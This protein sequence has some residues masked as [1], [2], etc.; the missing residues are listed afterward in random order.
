MPAKFFPTPADF[1]NWFEAN[2][3]NETELLV[4]FYKKDTGKASITWPESVD[5][6]LCFGWIDGIRRKIDEESY[7]IRF[8]PRKK[9]SNWSAVNIKRVAELTE[10]G[11][12][13][14]VGLK[15]FEQRK[16]DKSIIY[17]YEQRDKAVLNPEH[18]AQFKANQKAWDWFHAQAPSYQ[19]SAIWWVVSAKQEATRNKRIAILIAD[20]ENKLRIAFMRRPND[21][22]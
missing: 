14:P 4:G 6:A 3:E 17:S 21:P 13:K 11:L 5:Q 7:S 8:T 19:K 2:H 20:S 22:K 15:V 18:E 9:G 12:M 1:R 16:E 10:Q